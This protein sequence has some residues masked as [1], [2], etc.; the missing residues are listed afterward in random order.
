[1]S[2][3]LKGYFD[4]EKSKLARTPRSIADT[5]AAEGRGM[6][7]AERTRV[8][9]LLGEAEGF[10]TRIA[11][12]EENETIRAAIDEM[13]GPATTRTPSARRR[14]Q[15]VGDAFVK[16]QGYRP[17]RGLQ[18][19]SLGAKWTTGSIELPFG[20]KT[21]VTEAASPVIQPQVRAASSR[22]PPSRC[23]R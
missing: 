18:G 7:E 10:K 16:S 13:N 4:S 19:N 3:S 14:R 11:G 12:L 17:S 6:T 5:A 2:Q 21:T 9:T 22:P 15:V 8:S 23:V 1:M 20:T